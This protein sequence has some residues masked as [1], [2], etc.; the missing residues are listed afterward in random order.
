MEPTKCD[1]WTWVPLNYLFS[2]HGAQSSLERYASSAEAQGDTLG[3]PLD[4]LLLAERLGQ[5]ITGAAETVQGD[6]DPAR[7]PMSPG[8]GVGGTMAGEAPGAGA[9]ADDDEI[10]AFALAD[11]LAGGAS[12]FRPL[13]DLLQHHGELLRGAVLSHTQPPSPPSAGNITSPAPQLPASILSDDATTIIN[14]ALKAPPHLKHHLTISIPAPT[15]HHADQIAAILKVDKPLRPYD[16]S[17]SYWTNSTVVYVEV[18]ASTVRLL[19]LSVNAI[20]DDVS[21][22]VRTMEAFPGPLRAHEV[23]AM[24]QTQDG[25]EGAEDGDTFEQG[26]VGKVEQIN[27]VG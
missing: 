3:V 23:E 21:L 17:I 2:R 11:D 1:G 9:G 27:A 24:K 5:R 7:S 18:K 13:S 6:V 12:F 19:R 4:R 16:T 22:V 20:L 25:G 15:P 10:A 14:D 8:V 26:T